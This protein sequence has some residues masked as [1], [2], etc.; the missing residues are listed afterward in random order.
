MKYFSVEIKK[1]AAISVAAFLLYSMKAATAMATEAAKAAATKESRKEMSSP[2][3]FIHSSL[4]LALA[5]N[6][7]VSQFAQIS[8]GNCGKVFKY[9]SQ[10]F[11][12]C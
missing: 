2:A 5:R 7:T 8:M 11:T 9:I 3:L 1:F 12:D 6:D 4:L 10:P